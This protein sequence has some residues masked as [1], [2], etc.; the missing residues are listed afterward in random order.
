M[1]NAEYFFTEFHVHQKKIKNFKNDGSISGVTRGKGTK[2]NSPP[3]NM[4]RSKKSKGVFRLS[5]K[6]LLKKNKIGDPVF[7]VPPFEIFSDYVPEAY[8]FKPHTKKNLKK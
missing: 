8:M 7:F 4:E 5:K 3:R 6:F 1:T 2:E